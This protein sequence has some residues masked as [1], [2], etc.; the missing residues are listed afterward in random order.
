LSTRIK[1]LLALAIALATG[2][3][4]APHALAAPGMEIALQ[5]DAVFVYQSY[6]GRT[7]ALKRAQELHVTRIRANVSWASALG[8]QARYKHAPRRPLWNFGLWDALVDE[9]NS[10][11]IAVQLAL[12][13]PAPAFATSNH[14]I[15]PRGPK[16]RYYRLFVKAAAQHFAGRVDRFSIWNEPNYVGWI[17][18]LSQGPKL[19]RALYTTGYKTI[20]RYDPS[21]QVLFGET[22]PYWLKKRAT[23]PLDFIRRVACAKGN[24]RPARRCPTIQT[25]GF[26]HHPYDFDHPPTYRYPG[27]DNVTLRGLPKLT[28]ALTLMARYRLMQTPTGSAP[29]VYLTEYGFFSSGHRAVSRSRQA[30]Y[31]VKGFRMAQANPRVKEMLQ[32]LLVQP[33]RAY[34]FFDT[35]I[36]N[37]RGSPYTA[38]RKLAAWARGAVRSGAA[39]S[40]PERVT[41]P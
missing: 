31:L 29:Y 38:F 11:G 33:S 36:A 6:Y 18:P 2:L 22:S 16:A 3:T 35:S 34:R 25:D 37:R 24:W 40:K 12:T 13:G 4:A 39:A 27:A 9:A 21:A 19:Y 14:R 28:R 41:T 20:K 5:D 7:K 23:A 32:Y 30:S 1:T 17:A 15:G 8:R 10:K 26:A